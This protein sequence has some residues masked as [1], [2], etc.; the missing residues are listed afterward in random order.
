MKTINSLILLIT[1]LFMATSSYAQMDAFPD[2]YTVPLSGGTTT[3][4]IANDLNAGVPVTAATSN[5]QVY[6]TLPSFITFNTTTGVVTVAP[7]TSVG[8]YTFNYQVCQLSTNNC[9]YTTVTVTVSNLDMTLTGAYVD[10]NAN[11]FVDAGDVI[12][13]T[14]SVT[15]N[16]ATPMAPVNITGLGI[17]GVTTIPSLAVSATDNSTVSMYI[18]TETDI[19]NGFVDNNA[20]AVG[21]DGTIWHNIPV[22]LTTPLA[23]S[24]GIKLIAFGDTNGNGIKDI[25]ETSL[26]AGDFNYTINLGTTH[27]VASTTGEVILFEGNPLNSYYLSFTVNPSLSFA[28][29]TS[30]TYSGVTVPIS[31]GIVNYY[32]PITLLPFDDLSVALNPS[33]GPVPG[34]QYLNLVVLKNEGT[35]PMSGET[36]TYTCDP[37]LTISG[38]FPAGTTP[39]TST[40]SN[41]TYTIPSG[42][43]IPAGGIVVF[44]VQLQVPILGTTFPGY[45]PFALGD[46]LTN[47]VTVTAPSGDARPLNNTTTLIQD[48][49]GSYD[50]NDI[51]EAHGEKILFNTFSSS[52]YLTY[53]IRFENTGTGNA[54]NIKVD[55]ILDPKL[56]PSTIRMVGASADYALYRTGNNLSWTF[57][58]IDLPPSVSSTSYVGKGYLTYQIK[59]TAGYAIGD[60]IPNT[61]NIYFDFNP[62]IITNTFNTEFTSDLSLSQFDNSLISASPNPTSDNITIESMETIQQIEIYNVLGEKVGHKA[63]TSNTVELSLENLEKGSY[64]LKIVSEK[65]VFTK[66]IIKN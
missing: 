63:A 7:G 66:Q 35:S 27:N 46:L 29:A 48:V 26:N 34:F 64:L 2:F 30:T 41:F 59:P 6:M 49:R 28:Y 53:T 32:F 16:G 60:I 13:Y 14:Y 55:N 44:Y 58:G 5:L 61:A 50:P 19:N 10:Q 25:G 1:G 56:D 36:L 3:S 38:F 23:V 54:I 22:L 57:Y 20:S 21:D 52:D 42:S 12:N 4:V 17:T 8:V 24:D 51:H 47:T 45:S 18:L 62:A 33:R 43:P 65:G 39:T 9:D 11:T 37:R 15:N 31:S 40:T